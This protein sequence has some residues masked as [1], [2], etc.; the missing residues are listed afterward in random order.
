MHSKNRDRELDSIVCFAII[1]AMVV[2]LIDDLDQ[3]SLIAGRRAI[4]KHRAKPA[5]HPIPD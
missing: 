2:A 3:L 5:S 4:E 1:S